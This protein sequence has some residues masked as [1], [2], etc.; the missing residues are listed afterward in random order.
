[1]KAK[2]R[3]VS[4]TVLMLLFLSLSVGVFSAEDGGTTRPKS[5]CILPCQGDTCT[6]I[7]TPNV[8]YPIITPCAEDPGTTRPK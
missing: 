2:R 6:I 7:P 8:S 5:A 3:L 1:M 4:L